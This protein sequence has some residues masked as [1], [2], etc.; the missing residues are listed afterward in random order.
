MLCEQERWAV[1]GAELVAAKDIKIPLASG[2]APTNGVKTAADAD[3][4][5]TGPKR[6][7]PFG[8]GP[9]Q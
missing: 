1:P 8:A 6:F 4:A 2:G 3:A 9:R 5:G 7:L